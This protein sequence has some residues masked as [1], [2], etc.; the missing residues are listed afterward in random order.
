[1]RQE[2]RWD[3]V[4]VQH[5]PSAG[6]PENSRE[7]VRQFSDGRTLQRPAVNAVSLIRT[8]AM[9]TF[10]AAVENGRARAPATD[11][12]VIH[13]RSRQPSGAGLADSS[14]WSADPCP[15]TPGSPACRDDASVGSQLI[16]VSWRVRDDYEAGAHGGGPG[17]AR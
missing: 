1:M 16:E 4:L 6:C 14:V 8:S 11:G 9:D 3:L 17:F 7:R 2:V 5:P 15:E 12:G 10:A 13:R